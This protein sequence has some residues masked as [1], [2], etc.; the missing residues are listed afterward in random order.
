M[1]IQGQSLTL[2][3][4]SGNLTWKWNKHN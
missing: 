1:Q 2:I 3:R 4:T